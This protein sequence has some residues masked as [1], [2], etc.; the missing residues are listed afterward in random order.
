MPTLV[1]DPQPPELDDLLARRREWGA[2]RWDEVWKGVLHLIPPPSHDHQR[3]AARLMILLD[4]YA[5]T[6][7]LELT[8]EIGIGSDRRDFRVPDLAL[9]RP[10]A[11]AHWHPTAA[12]V[13]EIVSP[14]DTSWEKLPFYAAHHID[15]VLIVDPAR[16]QVHWLTLTAG[17]YQST[18]RSA[19]VDLRADEL[20]ARLDWPTAPAS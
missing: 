1:F 8:G 14:G 4:S 2:D 10:G 5:T 19:L 12:L 13:V 9:H 6:A 3:L 7:G 18:A 16:Q 15:E 17:A 20:A 11:A